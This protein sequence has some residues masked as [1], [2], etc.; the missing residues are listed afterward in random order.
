MPIMT[1]HDLSQSLQLDKYGPFNGPISR[2]LMNILSL[3]DL[4]KLYDRHHHL[5]G[6]AFID[7]VLEDLR[8]SVNVAD[9]EL[10][11]L[12]AKG[13]FIAVGNH[14][15]GAID[16]LVMLKIL[17][18]RH[19]ESAIMAN[20]LLKKIQPV[21][22]FICA[23][24]PFENHQDTFSSTTGVKQ[25]LIQLSNG[26]PLGIFP[27]GEVSVKTSGLYGRI[28]DKPWESGTSKLIKK[29]RVP[30]VPF[31]FHARN[32]H[33]FYMLSALNPGLRTASLPS[34][35]L[36]FRNKSITVRI[37]HAISVQEQDEIKD[38]N[39]LSRFLKHKTYV[40]G[41]S[42]LKKRRQ[43]YGWKK[44][45]ENP[46][47]SRRI[48]GANLQKLFE[49]MESKG[50]LILSK[51]DYHVYFSQIAEYPEI[52]RE[53]GLLREVTFRQV[54][55]GTSKGLDLDKFD[56]YYHHLILWHKPNMEIAGAYRIALGSQVFPKYGIKGFYISELFHMSGAMPE[57][58]SRSIE[59]GR[60]FIQRKYQNKPL[61]LFVLWQGITA[62]T[63]KYPEHIYLIGAA[64]I[65][66][67]YCPY[68]RM[69]MVEYL[70]FHEM[71]HLFSPYI[72][73]K[74]AFLYRIGEEAQRWVQR[75]DLRKMDSMV[76]DIEGNGIKMPVLI[77]KY[78]LNK[79]RILGFNV[80]PSFNNAIDV[81]MY[82]KTEDINLEKFGV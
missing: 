55:E 51:G 7:A 68:S 50:A 76:E 79:A 24:N 44:Y 31:Y 19:P 32:S 60:A 61:P 75:A 14:P 71:D 49:D 81:L 82:I 27:L 39:E 43:F 38:V 26:R 9:Y 52:K 20:F 3:K 22:D 72:T 16:G 59:M 70:K 35:V 21:S 62:V 28:L 1:H 5:T 65:S 2:S 25:A 63:K 34:E 69:M 6:L 66:S 41:E 45:P 36:K 8:I 73:P 40:L 80:D 77:K 78:L 30:V 11:R 29:A 23:V 67:S 47:F 57:F 17:L 13:P 46:D 33:V 74:K 10:K 54:G 4:N 15:L 18:T 42:L 56:D 37:G 53:L 12:P 64:S 58:M 48:S